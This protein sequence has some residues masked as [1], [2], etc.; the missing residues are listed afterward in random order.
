M[1]CSAVRN[2]KISKRSKIE[3]QSTVYNSSFD[4]YSYCGYRCTIINA[5]IGKFCSISDSVI[6]GQGNHPMNWVSTSPAFY[7]ERGIIKKDLANLS[8]PSE[9]KK[10]TIDSDVWIGTNVIIKSG[11]HIGVGAIVGMGSVVVKDVEPYTIVA[12]NPAKEIKKRFEPFLIERL[13][14]SKWW[15]LDYNELKNLSQYMDNPEVFLEHINGS[16]K[17]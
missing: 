4:D 5:S 1:P 17:K 8:F 9:T 12:G 3:A 14:G 11:V 6:I 16:N 2:S 7:K 10:I 15:E 13:I